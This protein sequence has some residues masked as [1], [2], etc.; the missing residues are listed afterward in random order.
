MKFQLQQ[1]GFVFIRIGK[2]T[3]YRATVEEF[4]ADHGPLPTL[5][6]RMASFIYDTDT[7]IM[8]FYDDC[9]NAYPVEGSGVD[10]PE[11]LSAGAAVDSLAQKMQARLTAARVAE[12]AAR[13]ALSVQT[14]V[15]T[16]AK[17]PAAT[18]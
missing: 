8:V 17:I 14:P 16:I 13:S 12:A 18:L 15:A 5:P 3:P 9:Q 6:P 1:D 7:R 11:C 2:E 4:L 10:V